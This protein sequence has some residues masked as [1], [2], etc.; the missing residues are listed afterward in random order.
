MFI[1]QDELNINHQQTADKRYSVLKKKILNLESIDACNN[2][3][4]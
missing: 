3:V 2:C 4:H 1:E